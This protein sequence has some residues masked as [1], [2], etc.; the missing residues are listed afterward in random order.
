[1]IKKFYAVFALLFILLLFSSQISCEK[2]QEHS[3]LAI[4]DKTT[5]LYRAYVRY[6]PRNLDPSK[7]DDGGSSFVATQIYCTLLEQTPSLDVKDSLT[8]SWTIDN[9]R[10]IYSFKLRDDIFFSN[11]KKITSDDV[12]F[13]LKRLLKKDSV[14]YA[15]FLV[16][17]DI[18]KKSEQTFEIR[19]KNPFPLFVYYLTTINTAILPKQ[20]LQTQNELFFKKPVGCGSFIFDEVSS[21][22]VV[23][24]ANNLAINRPDIKKLEFYF[25]LD[26]NKAIKMFNDNLIDDISMAW[27]DPTQ[28]TLVNSKIFHSQAFQTYFMML[29]KEKKPFSNDALRELFIHMFDRDGLIENFSDERLELANGLIPRGIIGF[30]NKEQLYKKSNYDDSEVISKL[31]TLRQKF[32]FPIDVTL[33][34]SNL[35]NKRAFEKVIKG[36]NID[37][38]F[39]IKLEFVS[40]EEVFNR[41]YIR[42]GDAI[43]MGDDLRY[44][45]PY[46]L[47]R[48]FKSDNPYNDVYV[49]SKI[50]DQYIDKAILEE[51]KYERAKI[52]MELDKEIEREA[53]ILPLFYGDLASG[54]VKNNVFGFESSYGGEDY[55]RYYNVWINK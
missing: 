19:L 6:P 21:D 28:F 45:D 17:K 42:Y 31:K 41:Y 16:V 24:I 39:R 10:T 4:T 5:P 22:R 18:E 8:E 25:D 55:I 9:T 23:L 3:S 15:D 20:E 52:Y 7:F 26:I 2:K 50:I 38:I 49:K 12:V 27:F 29:H 48:Y 53:V 34:V 40:P 46:L 11:G 43:L 44:P 54:V 47:L 35:F 13:S 1:M 37:K 14:V 30:N 51:N 36:N 32:K 33:T